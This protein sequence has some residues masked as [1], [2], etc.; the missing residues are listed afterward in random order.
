MYRQILVDRSDCNYQRI[1]WKDKEGATRNARLLTVTYGMKPSGYLAIRCL[2]Q[3]AIDDGEQYPVGARAVLSDFYVDDEMSGAMST[4]EALELYR[5]VTALLAG[6]GL[7]LRKWAS[8]SEDVLK[9]IPSALRETQVPLEMDPNNSVKS[10]LAPIIVRAKI[11][12]QS[13]WQLKVGWDEAIPTGQ[14]ELW[15]SF[16][17]AL[18]KIQEITIPRCTIATNATKFY[19]RGFCDASESAYAACIY[20]VSEFERG[21]VEVR[22]VAAKTRVA[23]LKTVSLPRLELCSAVLLVRVMKIVQDCLSHLQIQDVKAWTDSTVARDW[24]RGNPNRWKT[25]VANRVSEIRDVI[26]PVNWHHISGNENPADPASRGVAPGDLRE[27]K[28]WWNGPPWLSHPA[29]FVEDSSKDLS[30]EAFMEER[31]VVSVNVN[32]TFRSIIDN[33]AN[34]SQLRHRTATWL[35]F[36]ANLRGPKRFDPLDA[37]ELDQAEYVW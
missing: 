31:N 35:R 24:I 20:L 22:L 26:P 15:N 3:L 14:V 19:L 28:L 11:F 23:P 25:F 32:C 30:E 8:N 16:R 4:E 27:N 12:M 13:L 33:F 18:P 36:I 5:Q 6:G 21:K 1:L 37:V 7:E 29:A 10:L 17:E 9:E 2:R 34:I